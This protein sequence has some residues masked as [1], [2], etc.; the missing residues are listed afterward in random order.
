MVSDASLNGRVMLVAGATGGL[1]SAITREFARAGAHVLVHARTREKADMAVAALYAEVAGSRCTP[2]GADLSDRTQTAEMFAEINNV[3]GRLDGLVDAVQEHVPGMRG[4]F[5]TVDP[6]QFDQLVITTLG[7]FFHLCHGA[8]PL[9]KRSGQSA[10][11]TIST[12]AARF[13][14]PAQTMVGAVKAAI[15]MFTRNLAI[16]VARDGIR[17]N[18]ISPSYVRDTRIFDMI[19]SDQTKNRADT[20]ARRAGLGLPAAS[21]LA[22]LALFLVSANAAH[23]TGQVFSINGGLSA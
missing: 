12:D 11:V 5:E 14:A 8:L 19:M 23:I 1:G 15:I 20:A 4:R 2:Y 3:F 10:I 17:I 21:D 7:N 16:E 13:A 22:A 6:N 9:L 18:C